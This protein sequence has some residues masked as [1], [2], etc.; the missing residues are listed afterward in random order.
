M[1]SNKITGVCIALL[2][3]A[4]PL[5][6]AAIQWTF[7]SGGNGHFYEMTLTRMNWDV[8]EAFAV[9]QGGHLMSITSAAEQAFI[10]AT[11][12]SGPN[13]RMPLWLGIND[14]A[15]EGTF[16]WTTGEAVTFTAWDINEPNNLGD[17]DFGVINWNHA[18]GALETKGSWNDNHINGTVYPGPPFDPITLPYFAVVETVPEPA[19]A[20]L[21]LFG[22]ATC[23]RRRRA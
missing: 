2:L 14:V 9:S 4:G 12:L 21:L 10:L 11:F 7:A 15:V 6:A 1:K 20:A 18:A 23:L 8:A 5:S 19:S 13:D 22:T 3:S 17:E 16:V